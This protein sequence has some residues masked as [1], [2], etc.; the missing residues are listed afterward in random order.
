[1]S[2]ISLDGPCDDKAEPRLQNSVW[3]KIRTEHAVYNQLQGNLDAEEKLHT[4]CLSEWCTLV[5]KDIGL[6]FGI[7]VDADVDPG[8]DVFLFQKHKSC[9]KVIVNCPKFDLMHNKAS[10]KGAGDLF[11]IGR[12]RWD[13]LICFIFEI[14]ILSLIL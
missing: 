1:M 11:L 13:G 7:D 2:S 10:C 5:D 9:P 8:T 12:D 14:Y 3:G 6:L 4:Q